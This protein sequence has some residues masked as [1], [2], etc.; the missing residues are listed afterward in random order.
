MYT[1]VS[2]IGKSAIMFEKERNGPLSPD[3]IGV[4]ISVTG[5]V[6]AKDPDDRLRVLRDSDPIFPDDQLKTEEGASITMYFVNGTIFKLEENTEAVLDR[7]VFDLSLLDDL[8]YRP[9]VPPFMQ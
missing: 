8:A 7:E 2:Y 9:T 5:T 4:V 1:D 6:T 3:C